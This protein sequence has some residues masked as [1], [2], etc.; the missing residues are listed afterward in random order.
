MSLGARFWHGFKGSPAR[1]CLKWR[2]GTQSPGSLVNPHNARGIIAWIATNEAKRVPIRFA[3]LTPRTTSRAKICLNVFLSRALL[4][5]L[6]IQLLSGGGGLDRPLPASRLEPHQAGGGR[7]DA[8]RGDGG[9]GAAG[10]GGGGGDGG[11]G[12]AAE[13][14]G[15][16]ILV[17]FGEA[18]FFVCFWILC[19][20][21]CL[22]PCISFFFF[23]VCVCVCVC[24]RSDRMPCHQS[25]LR[26]QGVAA[27]PR[28]CHQRRHSRDPGEAVGDVQLCTCNGCAKSFWPVVSL[29]VCASC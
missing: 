8:A 18:G 23:L 27:G 26:Q 20:C 19:V 10:P 2:S 7:G 16:F 21:V 1:T 13:K 28:V 6:G 12:G 15:D 17:F 25:F 29:A 4:D 5:I 24:V 14:G 3:P 22:Q 9:E 11:S